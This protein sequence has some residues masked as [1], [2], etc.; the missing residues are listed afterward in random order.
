MDTFKKDVTA[1]GRLKYRKNKGLRIIS[2]K[3]LP[4]PL[5]TGFLGKTVFNATG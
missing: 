3:K 1:S 4:L 5:I 2:Q